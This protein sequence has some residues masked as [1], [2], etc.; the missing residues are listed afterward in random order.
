MRNYYVAWLRG[1][2]D[3]CQAYHGG[4]IRQAIIDL[5]IR[6]GTETPAGA[7]AQ[8]SVA[9]AQPGRPDQ[10][11]EHARHAGL[12]REEQDEQ[13]ASSRPSGSSTRATSITRWRSS[14]RSCWRTR[15]ASSPAAGDPTLEIHSG[16]TI[17]HASSCSPRSRSPA[18]A[19]RPRRSS[20][21]CASGWC[22]PCRQRP[23]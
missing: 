13:R 2:R 15:T 7:A 14:G 17:A 10:C 21:P 9:G 11:R 6:T 19:R 18:A 16:A 4:S 23:R 20:T 1:V 5:S 3:Y 8:I 12:V 22:A